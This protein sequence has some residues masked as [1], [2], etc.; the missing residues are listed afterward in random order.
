GQGGMAQVW[1][2]V[3]E[4]QVGAARKPVAIKLVAEHRSRS[5]EYR[6]LLLRE[7]RLSMLLNHSN[8]VQVFDV[9]EADGRVYMAMEWIDGLSL[10]ELQKRVA[11]AGRRIGDGIA[12]FIVAELLKALNHAHEHR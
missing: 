9:D 2:G 4:S 10:D 3:R 12:A 5:I 7:A 6:R 11:A 8:I 1:R